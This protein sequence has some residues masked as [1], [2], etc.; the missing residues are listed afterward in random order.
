MGYRTIL[1]VAKVATYAEALAKYETTA[2]IRGRLPR[3]STV[4]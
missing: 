1:R 2:P 3:G 4:G